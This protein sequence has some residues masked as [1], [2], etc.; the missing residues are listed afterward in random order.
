MT[1]NKSEYDRNGHEIT[2]QQVNEGGSVS[3]WID[4]RAAYA[5]SALEVWSG[6]ADSDFDKIQE[7]VEYMADNDVY[8]CR[9]C[10]TFYHYEEAA[11]YGFCDHK[12]GQCNK[13]DKMCEG[14]DSHDWECTNP[15]QKH[16][17]RVSTKYRC[18]DCGKKR[19]TVPT[20]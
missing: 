12:C 9:K 11:T 10:D 17:A 3:A 20:G 2:V 15:H 7:V 6:N 4:G 18:T 14:G 19:K 5:D 13:A 8:F 16:N 1:H